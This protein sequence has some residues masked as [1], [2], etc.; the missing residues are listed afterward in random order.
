ML[1]TGALVLY[2]FNTILEKKREK[3]SVK[4]VSNI[5]K[6]LENNRVLFLLDTANVRIK[7]K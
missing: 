5:K 1:T 6:A 7:N 2:K 4:Y 3:P